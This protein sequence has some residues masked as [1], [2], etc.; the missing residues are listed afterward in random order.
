MVGSLRRRRRASWDG[1]EASGT[2]R[3]GTLIETY[4]FTVIPDASARP[5]RLVRPG[6]LWGAP[7]RWGRPGTLGG[8]RG[9]LRRPR[10]RDARPRTLRFKLYAQMHNAIFHF[11]L[12][13]APHTR[14]LTQVSARIILTRHPLRYCTRCAVLRRTRNRAQLASRR[15]RARKGERWCACARAGERAEAAGGAHHSCT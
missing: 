14:A 7:G 6:T 13:L 5:G 3:P 10:T 12:R 8:V 15:A 2:G 11:E 1:N 4:L 9:R